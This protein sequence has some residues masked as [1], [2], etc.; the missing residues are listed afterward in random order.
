M[1]FLMKERMDQALIRKHV[2][3]GDEPLSFERF[4]GS[5]ESTALNR[6]TLSPFRAASNMR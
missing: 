3:A 6:R 2:R 1:Y 5:P 4:A